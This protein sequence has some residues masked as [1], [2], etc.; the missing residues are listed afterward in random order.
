MMG[1]WPFVLLFAFNKPL[2]T[3]LNQKNEAWISRLFTF[4]LKLKQEW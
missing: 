4:Q 1:Y 3:G 2:A